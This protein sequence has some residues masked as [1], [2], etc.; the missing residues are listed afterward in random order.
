ML[1][2]A[3]LPAFKETRVYVCYSLL[4]MLAVINSILHYTLPRLSAFLTGIMMDQNLPVGNKYWVKI[5][6]GRNL[7]YQ[8]ENYTLTYSK[9]TYSL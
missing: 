4:L 6:S 9:W 3:D 5:S 1:H 8:K 2:H 7:P